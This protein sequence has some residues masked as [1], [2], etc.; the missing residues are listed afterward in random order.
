MSALLLLTLLSSAAAGKG[1]AKKHP[2][3]PQPS[4][5]GPND[6]I[7][8]D[9]GGLNL[10]E[11]AKKGFRLDP[12]QIKSRSGFSASGGSAPTYNQVGSSGGGGQIKGTFSV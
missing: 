1:P 5:P 7:G 4:V 6:R 10:A 3:Q 12:K 11:L 8:V 2:P 9:L